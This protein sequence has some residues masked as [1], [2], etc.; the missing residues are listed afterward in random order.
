M[1][2]LREDIL[3]EGRLEHIVDPG[4]IIC[5]IDGGLFHPPKAREPLK[6]MGCACCSINEGVIKS[7]APIL[8]YILLVVYIN[9]YIYIYVF[10]KQQAGC[11]PQATLFLSC[12]SNGMAHKGAFF[13][14]RGTPQNGMVY[15]PLVFL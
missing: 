2:G 10:R 3:F 12:T 6:T 9:I 15:V 7:Q 11:T 13:F 1:V 14:F 8:Y 5:R 4:L